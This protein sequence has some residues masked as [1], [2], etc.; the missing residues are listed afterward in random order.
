MSVTPWSAT[1]SAQDDSEF[2]QGWTGAL[3]GGELYKTSSP[4]PPGGASAYAHASI[5][6]GSGTGYSRWVRDNVSFD[7]GDDIYLGY[8]HYIE[9][10]FYAMSRS[11]STRLCTIDNFNLTAFED[12]FGLWIFRSSNPILSVQ[13]HKEGSEDT[14]ILDLG[15][16][17]SVLPEGQWNLIEQRFKPH[18]T[19]GQAITTVWINGVEAGSNT[20]LANANS[21]AQFPLGRF[22]VGIA[23]ISWT[24]SAAVNMYFA[25]P[26]ID[27]YRHSAAVAETK[28]FLI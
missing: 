27:T 7:E 16:A 21:G 20:T 26:Y 10:G 8:Y 9:T 11:S 28:A 19:A 3:S 13:R 17:S 14:S 2:S 12:R 18:R 22:R 1:F 25:L 6:S 15:T 4:A 5:N 23:D 24:R